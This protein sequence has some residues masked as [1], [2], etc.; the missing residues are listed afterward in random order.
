MSA[1][2]FF[3][4]KCIKHKIVP[5]FVSAYIKKEN[6]KKSSFVQSSIRRKILQLEISELFRRRTYDELQAYDQHL[7][8]AR[9][10]P[11]EFWSGLEKA[12]YKIVAD[13]FWQKKQTLKRKFEWLLNTQYNEREPV[14]DKSVSDNSLDNNVINQSKV[15]LSKN[16]KL[17]L[18]KGLKS[19]YTYPKNVEDYIVGVERVIPDLKLEDRQCFRRECFSV[20]DKLKNT[21]SN[22]SKKSF[23]NCDKIVKNLKEKGVIITKADKGNKIVVMD[24]DDYIQRT[25]NLLK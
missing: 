17:L 7:K 3:L 13:R 11:P 6:H 23:N 24:T 21:E 25:E 16:E 1:D 15:T 5:K 2:I 8:L 22:Q 18:N 14:L 19:C 9:Y 12:L 10:F 4:N 20:L